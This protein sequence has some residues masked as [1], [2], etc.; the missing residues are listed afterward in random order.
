MTRSSKINKNRILKQVVSS[1]L[2]EAKLDKEEKEPEDSIDL[3][4]DRY[5]SDYEKDSR[6]SKNEGKDF[7]ML[8][9][10]FLL[11]A[12]A[13][14]GKEDKNEKKDEAVKKLSIEDIDVDNFLENVMRLIDN[15]DALLEVR[16]TI[17]ARAVNFLLKGYEPSTAEA[18]KQKLLDT[19][20][21]E[22]GKSKA[23]V[24]DEKYEIPD[25]DRAGPPLGA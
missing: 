5:F 9:R 13:E 10:R 22:V 19:Y 17:L 2:N 14:T 6:S 20:G 21:M 16:N 3:Q 23:E 1:L 11:E 18:F 15:Y 8:I 25:A 4:I 24:E 12:E 7:R